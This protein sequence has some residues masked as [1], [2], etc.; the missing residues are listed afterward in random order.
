MHI[1]PCSLPPVQGPCEALIPRYFHNITSSKCEKFYYGGCGGN[2]NNFKN[3]K[4][5]EK[6][7]KRAGKNCTADILIY[8]SRFTFLTDHIENKITMYRNWLVKEEFF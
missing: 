3:I 2:K 1:D 4:E 8:Y 7:C 5:C 6:N